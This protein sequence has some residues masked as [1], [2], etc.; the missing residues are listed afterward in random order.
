MCFY[1]CRIVIPDKIAVL[2]VMCA[3]KILRGTAR[4]VYPKM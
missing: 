2:R 3:F 1:F 4:I